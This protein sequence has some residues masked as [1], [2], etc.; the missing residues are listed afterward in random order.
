M[1]KSMKECFQQ[2]PLCEAW[3]TA[4]KQQG[5]KFTNSSNMLFTVYRPQCVQS[6][7]KSHAE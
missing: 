5:I 1:S 6:C 4:N 7:T 2:S 3:H